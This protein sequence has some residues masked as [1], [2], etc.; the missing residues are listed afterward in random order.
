MGWGDWSRTG[1]PARGAGL[2]IRGFGRDVT[3][4]RTICGRMAVTRQSD[5]RI[6]LETYDWPLQV[7][8]QNS[9]RQSWDGSCQFHL[10]EG[11]GTKLQQIAN[12]KHEYKYNNLVS[13]PRRARL[14]WKQCRAPTTACGDCQGSKYPPHRVGSVLG[15][16]ACASLARTHRC[17]PRCPAAVTGPTGI[18]PLPG[19]CQLVLHAVR[20]TF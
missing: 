8:Q 9:P 11:G 2:R 20:P 10:P 4:T 16:G 5:S 12:Y 14:T 15:Q 18:P 6:P 1:A 19:P 13:K 7:W 3:G 17:S